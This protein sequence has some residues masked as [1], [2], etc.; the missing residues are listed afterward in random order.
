GEA[1][2]DVV[3]PRRRGRAAP[4]SAGLG[5]GAVGGHVR[6]QTTNPSARLSRSERPGE[7]GIASRFWIGA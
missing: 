7:N 2:E 4:G 5:Q 6:R 3:H 1:G